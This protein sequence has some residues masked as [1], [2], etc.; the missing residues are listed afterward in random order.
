MKL[1]IQI[2]R[3]TLREKHNSKTTDKHDIPAKVLL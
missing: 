2:K 1:H 3:E